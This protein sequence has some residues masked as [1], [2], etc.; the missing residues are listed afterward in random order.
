MEGLSTDLQLTAR[1]EVIAIELNAHFTE[2]GYDINQNLV[3]ED[4]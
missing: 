2:L 3:L 1:F 4:I